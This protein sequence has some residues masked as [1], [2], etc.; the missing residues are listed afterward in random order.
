M[1]PIF[2]LINLFIVDRVNR[3]TLLSGAGFTLSGLYIIIT[4]MS[5]RFPAIRG[6]PVNEAAQYVVVACVFAISCT[7]SATLGPLGWVY[8]PEIFQVRSGRG[9]V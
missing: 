6:Q 8:P 5:A 9:R 3:V 1:G 4:A 7:F 2:C